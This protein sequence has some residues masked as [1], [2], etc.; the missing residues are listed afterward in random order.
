MRRKEGSNSRETRTKDKKRR[1]ETCHISLISCDQCMMSVSSSLPLIS[2][3]VVPPPKFVLL[4][5]MSYSFFLLLQETQKKKSSSSSWIPFLF[6]FWWSLVYSFLFSPSAWLWSSFSFTSSHVSR[7]FSSSSLSLVFWS[8][9]D[10]LS[11]PFLS[12]TVNRSSDKS[13]IQR[14]TKT[15]KWRTTWDSSLFLLSLSQQDVVAGDPSFRLSAPIESESGRKRFFS[16]LFSCLCSS[17]TW[18]TRETQDVRR[19][20]RDDGCDKELENP[21]F[22]ERLWI[23]SCLLWEKERRVIQRVKVNRQWET[24]NDSGNRW[25]QQKTPHS[26]T[27]SNEGFDVET[28]KLWRSLLFESWI[29]R[30]VPLQSKLPSLSLSLLSC[31]KLQPILF[32]LKQKDK[33]EMRGRAAEFSWETKR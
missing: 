29:C 18:T 14:L 25:K 16:S 22:F 12:A 4:L 6:P 19:K 23:L 15:M 1:K 33:H 31:L 7:V 10:R 21:Q 11:D 28:S 9:F 32:E 30:E 13:S 17:L 27:G 3:H 20:R 26:L 8:P 5:N 24:D 2:S